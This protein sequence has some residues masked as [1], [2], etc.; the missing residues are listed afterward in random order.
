MATSAALG[1]PPIKKQS[2]DFDLCLKCQGE[3]WVNTKN[4]GRELE[5]LTYPK[6]ESYQKFLD[7]TSQRAEYRNPDFVHLNQRLHGLSAEILERNHAVWHRTC[8]SEVTHKGHTDRDKKRYEKALSA[9]SSSVLSYKKEGGRPMSSSTTMPDSSESAESMKR[10]L[11]RSHVSPFNRELCFYCQDIK[12]E[13]KHARSGSNP[14]QVHL[15]RTSDIG[16]SV[17][18]I[19]DASHNDQW[20]LNMADIL[21]EGDFL[22]RDIRYHTS[23]HTM[24]WQRYV[25]QPQRLSNRDNQSDK[26]T[27]ASISAEIE[28]F[29]ELK[30]RLNQGDIITLTEV[31][32]L[33]TNMM[34]DHGIHNE[35]ITRQVLLEKIQQNIT[36][37]TITDARGRKP[38]VLHSNEAGR[39]AIDQAIEERD[40]KGEMNTIFRCSNIIR[41][42][43]LRSRKDD[44]WSFNGSLVGCSESGVPAE[45]II[46]TRWVLQ[47]AKAATTE[48]RTE[49]LHNSCLILSQ[50]IVQACKTDRQVTLT[51]MS[52]ESTFHSM[53]ESPYAVGLSLYM[54]HNFR[55]QKAV[56]LL[57]KFGVGVS[58]DRVTKI[59]NNIANAI[60]QN[61]REYGVYVP[62]GLLRNKRIRASLDNIDKKVDT[63]DG[64]GSFHGTALGVYQRS[65]QGETVVD[66]VQFSESL[67]S[68]GLQD[69]PPTVID[70]VACTIE[71]NPKPKTSPHYTNYKMGVYDE[72]YGRSQT[73]DIGWMVARF[74]NRPSVHEPGPETRQQRKVNQKNPQLTGWMENS[75]YLFGLPTIHSHI[76][77]CPRMLPQ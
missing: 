67:T 54:Y 3:Q 57:S 29:A 17:K 16:K 10:S 41:Q 1:E 15:C 74:F 60:S 66:P 20:K 72:S 65:D 51:P 49:H 77:H 62:P 37:F 36:N 63:P 28:F 23:C 22:S 70:M 30:E 47:G 50:S 27:V 38:A 64:K 21:A 69:V 7:Y 34:H 33:Y 31:A 13:K 68:A 59:R 45:L 35:K 52:S 25:Q 6:H 18:K 24:H 12:H 61:I 44:P 8:Y 58:Y 73:N 11:T 46:F 40:I 9:K 14:E 75:L 55:S 32:A 26:D 19:V 43:V 53:F 4:K 5:S 71:G 2:I 39:S 42:A 76:S 56:S 48:T